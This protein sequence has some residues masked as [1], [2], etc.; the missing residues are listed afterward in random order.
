MAP[1][2]AEPAAGGLFV[3]IISAI[4]L[5]PIVL[6]LLSA[7][8]WYFAAFIGLAAVLM[9]V[10][11]QALMGAASLGPAGILIAA[12]LLG[13]IVLAELDI[14]A[15]AILLLAAG[16]LALAAWTRLRH[17]EPWWQ[18]VG[19]L[20]L[21]LPCLAIIWLR[22]ETGIGF[23][24]ALWLLATVWACDTG[25]Y[26]AGRAI[27][28]PKLAPRISPKK[29]WAGLIGGMAAAAVVGWVFTGFD[30]TGP[31]WA[32]AVAGALIAAVSQLGDLAES[33]VKRHFGV[34]DSGA[35]IPGH[36][37]VLDRVDGLLFAAPAAAILVYWGNGVIGT[38]G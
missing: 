30:Y 27:G 3:R 10:E 22:N 36:G 21:G 12:A 29:T 31:A 23:T 17:E 2:T 25:A 26:F 13:A 19:V 35:L 28:G 11:W 7:G 8:G 24:G 37:G 32:I 9:T 20:W 15:V 33:A 38:W 14:I 34:K 6:L 4:V 1:P 16:V 18:W 5:L